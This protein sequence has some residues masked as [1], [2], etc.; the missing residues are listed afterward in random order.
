MF[1]RI[2]KAVQ[3]D[4]VF[5]SLSGSDRITYATAMYKDMAGGKCPTYQQIAM[6]CE[7]SKQWAHESISLNR[8]IEIRDGRIFFKLG[9][10]RVLEIYRRIYHEAAQELAP[11]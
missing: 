2:A 5:R 11:S 3:D 4:S 10:R 6:I 1:E 7:R 9:Y 8:G